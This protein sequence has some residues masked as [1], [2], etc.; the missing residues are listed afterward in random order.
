MTKRMQPVEILRPLIKEHFDFLEDQYGFDG[1]NYTM[2]NTK[3]KSCC[4]RYTS[5]KNPPLEISVGTWF[6]DFEIELCLCWTDRGSDQPG[7]TRD[8]FDIEEVNE[9]MNGNKCKKLFRH[10]CY[11]Y[12][13]LKAGEA[14]Q[15]RAELL[16]IFLEEI[17]AAPEIIYSVMMRNRHL[18]LYRSMDHCH[19]IHR[20]ELASKAWIEN[21]YE[22]FMLYAENTP[23]PLTVLDQDRYKI[24]RE[25]L[26]ERQD[27]NGKP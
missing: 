15:Q 5:N 10:S 23:D 25:A 9:A 4:I 21:D 17:K 27:K 20:K 14:L 12:N 8:S 16:T 18:H 26:A 13:E 22:A 24:A 3:A 6:P 7:M 19:P 11:T 1:A 2:G